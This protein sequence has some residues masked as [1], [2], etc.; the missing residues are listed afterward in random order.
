MLIKAG[1]MRDE[2][3]PHLTQVC[4]SC[5]SPYVQVDY[6]QFRSADEPMDAF[7]QCQDCETKYVLKTQ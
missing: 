2:R 3:T 6:V 4:R 5:H 7:V 1:K